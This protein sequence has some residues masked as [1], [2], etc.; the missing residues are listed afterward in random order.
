MNVQYGLDYKFM[1][2]V[3]MSF[4]VFAFGYLLCEHE[5]EHL[6]TMLSFSAD[7]VSSPLHLPTSFSFPHH[8]NQTILALSVSPP[9]TSF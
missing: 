3:E 6:N 2:R 7:Q 8:H 5:P 1:R 9:S 4:G